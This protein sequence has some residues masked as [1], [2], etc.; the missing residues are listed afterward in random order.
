MA[1]FSLKDAEWSIATQKRDIY[2]ISELLK[3]GK[4]KMNDK[5]NT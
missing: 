3:I 4:L 2:L 1:K 5:N